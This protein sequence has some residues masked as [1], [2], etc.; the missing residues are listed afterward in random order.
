[1]SAVPPP[2]DLTGAWKNEAE[3]P[4]FLRSIERNLHE[5]ET[6]VRGNRNV[7]L[8]FFEILQN[9][10]DLLRGKYLRERVPA[11]TANF[12]ALNDLNGRLGII[13]AEYGQ[14]KHIML[15]GCADP[16]SVPLARPQTNVQNAFTDNEVKATDKAELHGCS[17]IRM[18]GEGHCLFRA[19]AAHLLTREHL[20]ELNRRHGELERLAPGTGALVDE[21]LRRLAANIAPAAMLNDEAFSNAWVAALRA[22]SVNWWVKL[23]EKENRTS[24]E[25]TTLEDFFVEARVWLGV[26]GP[27]ED[28]SVLRR[29]AADMGA[30]DRGSWGGQPEAIAIAQALGVPIHI[31]DLQTKQRPLPIPQVADPSHI[32]LLRRPGHFDALFLQPAP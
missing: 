24:Q 2:G 10:I 18:R 5:L 3:D 30:M 11:A 12:Q 32:Y 15:P 16:V 22:I 21:S 4:L 31:I 26:N 20:D 14:K 28:Q 1:M 8:Y 19:I 9:D 6:S 27:E 17:V 25:N 23:Y 29:Y 13:A 7:D